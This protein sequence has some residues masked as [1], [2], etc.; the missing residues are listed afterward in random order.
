MC[1]QSRAHTS[2]AD[3]QSSVP[4]TH[5][6]GSQLPINPVTG[7]LMLFSDL[8]GICTHAACTYMPVLMDIHAG[9]HSDTPNKA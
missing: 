4:S 8:L 5:T 2:F 7:D 3:T 6:G 1:H 9:T